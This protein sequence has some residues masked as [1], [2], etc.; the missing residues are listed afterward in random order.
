MS[1]GGD[2]DGEGLL[3][4]EMVAKEDVDVGGWM[5]MHNCHLELAAAPKV[6]G[7]MIDNELTSSPN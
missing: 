6:S 2:G 7:R 3:P 5:A 1:K 4:M